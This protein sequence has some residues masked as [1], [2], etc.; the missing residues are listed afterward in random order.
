MG[1]GEEDAVPSG[2][3]YLESSLLRVVVDAAGLPPS[4]FSMGSTARSAI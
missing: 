1:E 4:E 2:S 3:E